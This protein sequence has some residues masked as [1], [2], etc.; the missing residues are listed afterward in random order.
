MGHCPE[1]VVVGAGPTGLTVACELL[2]RGMPC[3]LIDREAEGTASSRA[4]G[5][6]TRSLEVLAGI[7][8]AEEAVERGLPLRAANLYSRGKRVGRVGTSRL[9]WTRFPYVL[10]LPQRE[11]E[12]L[13]VARL[14]AFGGCVER[15][16]SLVGMRGGRDGPLEL[17][18]EGGEGTETVRAEW[19][20]GAD[21]AHSSVRKL[22]G[23]G[24]AGKST[25]IV[26]T[27]ADA[28]VDSGPYTGEAHYYF[29]PEGLLVVI[30]LPGGGYRIAATVAPGERDGG[31]RREAIQ[32]LVDRRAPRADMRIGALCDAG[33]GAARV[34]IHTRLADAYRADRCLLAGDSAHI[35]S[36]VGGQG[37]N[38]GIQDAHN[39]AW[40]LAL[41]ASGRAP[42]SL[43]LSY[44]SERRPAAKLTQRAVTAQTRLATVGSRFGAALRD[45]VIERA[46]GRGVLDRRLAPQLAQLQLAYGPSSAT[47]TRRRWLRSDPAIGRRVPDMPLVGPG[48]DPSSLFELLHAAEFLVLALGL[49]GEP[50]GELGT[51]RGALRL[52]YAELVHLEEIWPD[53]GAAPPGAF[54]DH[55]GLLHRHFRVRGPQLLLVRPD[56]H[57]AFRGPL[58][59]PRALLA[60]LGDLLAPPGERKEQPR[61]ERG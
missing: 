3:R 32:A 55:G 44:E 15:G 35:H 17:D 23:I 26:F 57:L 47:A 18:C 54:A 51:V 9:R 6:S 25:E 27:I 59:S 38:I 7:G 42:D 13:L 4:V 24:F 56:A 1:I 29:S 28:A 33:W 31:L 46:S 58:T 10:S 41:V 30:P 34:R 2:R 14:E 52:R 22:A 39:L 61:K 48:G 11:T 60:L 8:A 50:P 36:P 21:G 37:V 5:L 43:L 16:V 20:V 12:R 49:K 53:A 45:G 40:K 19:V